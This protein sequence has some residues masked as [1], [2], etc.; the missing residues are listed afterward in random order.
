MTW[1]RAVFVLAGIA[2][3]QTSALS[4]EPF[5][6]LR[7][8]VAQILR[9]EYP[10]ASL[11]KDQHLGNIDTFAVNQRQ[12]TIYR[13]DKVGNWQRPME[14]SAPDRGGISVRFYVKQGMWTG[15]LM[16]P[17]VGTEDL[18]V[19]KETHVVRNSH[20][21]KWHIWAEILTPRA[22]P[23]AE[24]MRKLVD[25]FDEFERYQQ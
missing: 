5:D 11:H 13:L 10:D 4:H 25:V 6:S 3:S 23:P 17:Y 22:D 12:F 19:F 7:E 20:D 14:V 21:G 24:V 16:V 8:A 18:Y 15:A 2:A 1:S 9:S